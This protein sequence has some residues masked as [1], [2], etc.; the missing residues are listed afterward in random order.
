MT[1]IAVCDMFFG[2][3]F[4]KQVRGLILLALVGFIFLFFSSCVT[5]KVAIL[6]AYEQIYSPIGKRDLPRPSQKQVD[7]LVMI[8]GEN[9]EL[10]DEYIE[11]LIT[12][13]SY[14]PELKSTH[15]IFEYSDEKTT[16]ACRPSRFLFPR[17]YKVLINK[18]FDGIPFDSIPWNASVG[19]VGHELAHIVDYESLN[20]FG[21]IDRLLLYANKQYGKPYFEKS[22][23]LI[24]INRGL[25]W[26]L[27]D[28]AKY[29]MYDNNVASEE[30][31]E[32]KQ[33]TY[34]TPEIIITYI[35]HYSKYCQSIKTERNG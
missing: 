22:V 18:N 32:F 30:Y 8:Y 29:A 31:K 15:I 10:L 25:G 6:P 7:S 35:N 27:Y 9:K 2:F 34:L 20:L 21:L 14:Y 19:I 5:R 11:I 28:W 12:A 13:L 3:L 1:Y 17:T 24:T 4:T 26:Q 16:M 23:D 33:R